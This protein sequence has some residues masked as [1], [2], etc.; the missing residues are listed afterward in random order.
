MMEWIKIEEALP[1]NTDDVL[2]I[3]IGWDDMEFHVILMYEDD[4]WFNDGGYSSGDTVTHWMPLPI[5]PKQKQWQL[6]TGDRN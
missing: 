6:K 2:C 1:K 5:T 4:E 3:I